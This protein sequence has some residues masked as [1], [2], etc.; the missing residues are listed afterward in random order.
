VIPLRPPGSLGE[1]QFRA[2][3]I[4]CGNCARAC[5]GK[6]LEPDFGASGLAG[7]LTPVVRFDEDYCREDCRLCGQVCPSGAIA[8]LSLAEKRRQIIGPARVDDDLCWLVSGR[9]CTACIQRCPYAAITLHSADG[10]FTTEPRVDLA[11]CTGCGACEVVCPVRPQRAIRVVSR[12]GCDSRETV[13][14]L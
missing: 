3:C 11:K 14:K 7:L 6:I 5:P 10:G 8:R 9:E 13:S 2:V 4:R 1:D 12:T